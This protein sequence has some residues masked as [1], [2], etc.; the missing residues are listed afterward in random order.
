MDVFVLLG[1]L[2]LIPENSNSFLRWLQSLAA[3]LCDTRER[4]PYHPWPVTNKQG[5]PH[6]KEWY[7]FQGINSPKLCQAVQRVA[8][9]E[10]S[11][12]RLETCCK[13]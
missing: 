2:F 1:N 4:D 7:R 9:Y 10:E 8:I 11:D 6:S 3:Y 12:D 13:L 5:P